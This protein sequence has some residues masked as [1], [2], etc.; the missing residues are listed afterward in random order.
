MPENNKRIVKMFWADRLGKKSDVYQATLGHTSDMASNSSTGELHT[1]LW[2]SFSR[3][4]TEN[5]LVDPKFGVS[6]IWFTATEK[7]RTKTY[8][9]DGVGFVVQDTLLLGD[10]SCIGFANNALFAH[11]K[12]AVRIHQAAGG[13]INRD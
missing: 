3:T 6:K 10:S 2:Y 8:D 9:Q 13:S 1:A 11:L 12:V 5:A 7:G 4:A